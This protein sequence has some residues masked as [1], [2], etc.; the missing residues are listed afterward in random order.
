MYSAITHSIHIIVETFYDTENSSPIDER[1]IFTYHITIK[2]NGSI[3]IK[4]LKRKWQIK[5]VVF[6]LREVAGD[7]VIGMSPEIYP[8]DEFNYF[9]NVS[10]YSGI[11]LMQGHYLLR[12]LNTKETFEVEIPKFSL[13]AEVVYN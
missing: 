1:Y 6:G 3:P 13:I 4:L 8:G 5:D 7:G 10:L 11:G 9:S 2:N 12:N